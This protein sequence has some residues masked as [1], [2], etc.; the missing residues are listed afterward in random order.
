MAN[1][2]KKTPLFPCTDCNTLLSIGSY[3]PAIVLYIYNTLFCSNSNPLFHSINQILIF[4]RLPGF[5]I[6]NTEYAVAC[7]G[8]SAHSKRPKHFPKALGRYCHR[9]KKWR[10]PPPWLTSPPFDME[11]NLT[12]AACWGFCVLSIRFTAAQTVAMTAEWEELLLFN[13]LAYLM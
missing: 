3:I 7:H 11:T 1:L 8:L 6:L 12:G 4:K 9:H 10:S 2:T 13:Q 5:H